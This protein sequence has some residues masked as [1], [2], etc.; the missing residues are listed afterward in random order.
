[1]SDWLVFLL[2]IGAVA[3]FYLFLGLTWLPFR[4]C[5]PEEIE[6]YFGERF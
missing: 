6:R 1:M 4:D 2:A 3:G 5:T